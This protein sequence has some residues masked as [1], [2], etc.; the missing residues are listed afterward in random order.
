MFF[1]PTIENHKPLY[2][3]NRQMESTEVA[4]IILLF[5]LRSVSGNA[6]LVSNITSRTAHS[7]HYFPSKVLDGNTS[8]F[9]HSGIDDQSEWLN[10]TL[11]GGYKIRSVT[12]FN[13]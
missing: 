4:A 7:V 6:G 9:Y 1:I 3:A 11:S 13:R 8:T 12:I 2:I 10:L 5:L